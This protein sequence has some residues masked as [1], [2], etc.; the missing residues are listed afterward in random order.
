MQELGW[1]P[2]CSD[3][4]FQLEG[5]HPTPPSTRGR[6][7]C[8]SLSRTLAQSLQGALQLEWGGRGGNAL[9]CVLS[10]GSKQ[11]ALEG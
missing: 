3:T 7:L 9:I 11:D 1:D 5:S 8:Q 10:L 4:A 2:Q 6:L